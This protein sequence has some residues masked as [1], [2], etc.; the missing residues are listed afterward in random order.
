MDLEKSFKVY[1]PF[2]LYKSVDDEG[3]VYYH[4]VASS[5][6]IDRDNEK[7]SEAV[8]HKAA[9]QLVGQ[10]V[11]FN[12]QHKQLGVGKI[13]K[14]WNDAGFLKIQMKPTKAAGMQDVIMQIEEGI[15][16]AFSI[17]GKTIKRESAV[18]T[19]GHDYHVIKDADFYEVSVVG[20]PANPDAQIYGRI[21]KF[22][23][24]EVDESEVDK[25]KRE[26]PWATDAQ[27]RQIVSDHEKETDDEVDKRGKAME[28]ETEKCREEKKDEKKE[29][30]KKE[31]V[32]KE[33][34]P[35]TPNEP[36]LAEGLGPMLERAKADIDVV[37]SHLKAS[38]SPVNDSHTAA[39]MPEKPPEATKEAPSEDLVKA[40]KENEEL[41]KKVEDLEIKTAKTKSLVVDEKASEAPT[42]V[43]KV[44][45]TADFSK[46][47]KRF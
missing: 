14:A 7:M 33:N 45:G 36:K 1:A 9:N 10:P 18:D 27:A 41:K 30:E 34:G 44:D 26:Y 31:E 4:G 11:F 16:K 29:D 17:G 23:K 43:A 20:I 35:S 28:T 15:L 46:A 38:E 40:L 47:C 39:P 25:E 37:L 24:N 6:S 13:T 42:Q 22:L 2:D 3:E 5:S 19:N 12:H 21:A 8:L 32:K